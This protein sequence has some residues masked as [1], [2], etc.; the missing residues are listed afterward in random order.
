MQRT[1]YRLGY[2]LI[3]A[4]SAAILAIM[5]LQ[6]I[7]ANYVVYLPGPTEEIGEMVETDTGG[8]GEGAFLLTAVYQSYPDLFSY[9]MLRFDPYAEFHKREEVFYEGETEEQYHSRQQINMLGS[10]N[11][12]ILAVYEELGIPYRYEDQGLYVQSVIAD[13]PAAEVLQL[14]DRIE[15]IDGQAVT[16]FEDLKQHLS[17]KKEGDLAAVTFLRGNVRYTEEIELRRLPSSEGEEAEVGLGVSLLVMRSVEPEDERYRVKISTEDIGG[18]SAGLMFAL[19][20]YNRFVPEDI[21][22]GY[23]IAGTGEISP[24]GDV[25]VIGGIRHKVI[26]AD[27]DGADIFLAPADYIDEKRGLHI[28]NYS[29]AVRTAEEIGSNMQI[30]EVRTLSDALEYLRKLPPK[31]AAEGSA[32]QAEEAD[33]AEEAAAAGSFGVIP[34]A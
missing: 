17:T 13:Y 12:A 24:E 33:A 18:P 28:E 23:R 30:V 34:A 4:M 25:G 7:P 27:R 20:I 22:R 32:G 16:R 9:L 5:I 19:E 2:A 6:N 8:K 3:I 1:L 21:S 26:G 15:A 31:A 14:W 29:E 10:Q 11:H